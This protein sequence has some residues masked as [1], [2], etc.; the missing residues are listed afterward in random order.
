MQRIHGKGSVAIESSPE[1]AWDYMA[2]TEN[3]SHLP[4][5]KQAKVTGNVSKWHDVNLDIR[6]YRMR[7]NVD[8]TFTELKRPKLMAFSGNVKYSTLN[9][10][11][12]AM[13]LDGKLIFEK[14]V[15][16]VSVSIDMYIYPD[17]DPINITAFFFLTRLLNL[18]HVFN[19][20][21]MLL[22]SSFQLKLEDEK[23]V[24]K[25]PSPAKAKKR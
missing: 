23:G 2:N 10:L 11:W 20:T 22:L 9:T 1:K 15:S 3:W 24:S 5:L 14:T 13:T 19:N 12:P 8:I 4:F 16:G 6:T 17:N 21:I 18:E 25:R 7:H